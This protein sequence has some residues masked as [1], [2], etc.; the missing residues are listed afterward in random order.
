MLEEEGYTL[1]DIGTVS[2]ESVD[3]PDYAHPM[4]RLIVEGNLELGIMICGTGNGICMAANKH[5]DIRAA[6]CWED[7]IAELARKHND[8]NVLGLPARFI[9]IEKAK[10]VV[11]RFLITKFEG[12]RHERRVMKINYYK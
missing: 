12:G 7:K 1:Q 5:K 8:A 11:K 10:S 9:S 6:L 2:E 3:Y 4:A